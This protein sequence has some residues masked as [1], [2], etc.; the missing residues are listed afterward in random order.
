[1][2][3]FCP[4]III[5]YPPSADSFFTINP[6]SYFHVFYCDSLSL[7]GVVCMTISRE[8]FNGSE[9]LAVATLGEGV[10]WEMLPSSLA[11]VKYQY[12]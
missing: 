2:I 5:S 4:P 12:A 8:L 1:M 7:V 3:L 9:Q 6:P 11:T 10:R